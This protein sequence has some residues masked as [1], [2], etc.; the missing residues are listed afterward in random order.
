[1]N[2]NLS[3]TP[4]EPTFAVKP[5][6]QS[7]PVYS[8]GLG[9]SSLGS[10]VIPSPQTE[11]NYDAYFIGETSSDDKNNL[12]EHS[13]GLGTGSNS[14][15]SSPGS[16]H[17]DDVFGAV[18]GGSSNGFLEENYAPNNSWLNG[19]DADLGFGGVTAASLMK[20]WNDESVTGQLDISELWRETKLELGL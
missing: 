3:V 6:H 1:M 15:G 2:L 18:T 13:L 5:E 16:V 17:L 4:Q 20:I 12:F 7:P 19:V 11:N 10:T 8:V 9:L 14:N